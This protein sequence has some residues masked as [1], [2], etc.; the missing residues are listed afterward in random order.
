MAEGL[1]TLGIPVDETPDG[2]ELEGGR[3]SGGEVDS[4]GDHRI[5]M[6]FAIAGAFADAPVT[7][8]NTQN[9]ET[10]YPGFVADMRQLGLDI[11][12]I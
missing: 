8:R 12:E 6:A 4:H 7:I 9:I 2:L 10:S 11:E 1:R 3:F 5:A